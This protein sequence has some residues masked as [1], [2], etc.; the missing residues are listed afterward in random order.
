MTPRILIT[1]MAAAFIGVAPGAAQTLLLDPIGDTE[2]RRT[3]FGNDGVVNVPVHRMPD[4]VG[5]QLGRWTPTDPSVD[6]YTGD[7]DPLGE[8]VRLDFG[9]VNIINPPGPLGLSVPA[10]DPYRY[11][12]HP[13]YGFVEIDMDRNLATGGEVQQPQLRYLANVARFGGRPAGPRFANRVATSGNDLNHPFN[14]PPLVRRS[15]EEFHIALLGDDI[16]QIIEL[17]GDGDLVFEFGDVWLV[18]GQLFHRAHGYEEFSA[19]KGPPPGTYKPEVDLRWEFVPNLGTT[20]VTLVYPLT[21]AAS[22]QMR[23]EGVVEPLNGTASDQN[24]IEEALDDLIFSV[25]TLPADDPNRLDPQFPIIAA[26]ENQQVSEA[27]D[28]DLWDLTFLA[29][30]TYQAPEPGALFA[31]T[32]V[33]PGPMVGDMNGNG[34]VT[35]P[36]VLAVND[37]IALHDGDGDFDSG[38]AGDL[39]VELPDFAQNFSL[40]DVNYDGVVDFNDAQWVPLMGDLDFDLDVDLADRAIFTTALVSP[41]LLN[42][43]PEFEKIENRA[44]FR[45]DGILD[46]RDMQGFVNRLVGPPPPEPDPKP[47]ASAAMTNR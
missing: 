29:G 15:G 16:Q 31:W 46:G 22:A 2:L 45:R 39:R 27:L 7:W 20:L 21:Q 17:S 6:P 23:G 43:P 9:F 18:R 32:D 47:P 19:S 11:G 24:S 12:P 3:D 14:E 30:M 38:S 26:W 35:P 41:Q 28:A 40:F 5:Y 36:D 34:A 8:F 4:L 44:D 10:Y 25:Q 37:F 1:V 13:V 42:P 33:Q